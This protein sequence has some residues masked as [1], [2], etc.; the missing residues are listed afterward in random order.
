MLKCLPSTLKELLLEAGCGSDID[1]EGM[2]VLVK[3]CPLLERVN[4]MMLMNIS[5]E[6]YVTSTE[7]E[8]IFA[9][10]SIH[11]QEDLYI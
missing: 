3:Q 6:G 5:N 1:D 10:G 9:L 11:W 2:N 8:L 4:K 7:I